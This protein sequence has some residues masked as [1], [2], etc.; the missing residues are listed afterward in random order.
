MQFAIICEIVKQCTNNER[1]CF[2]TSV[3]YKFLPSLNLESWFVQAKPGATATR[4]VNSYE[5]RPE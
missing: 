2:T 1:D 4:V 5:V 3:L